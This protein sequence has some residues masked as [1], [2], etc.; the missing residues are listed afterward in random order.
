VSFLYNPGVL[1]AR[2]RT[3]RGWSQEGLCRGICA[4][5]YLSKIESG[6]AEASD[7]ILSL[8]FARLGIEWNGDLEAEAEALAEKAFEALFTADYEEL[9]KL[10]TSCEK[11]KY[12]FTT[13]GMELEL[14]QRIAD[15]VREPLTRDME[16]SMDTRALAIQRI[17]QGRAEEAVL[18]LPNACAYYEAGA[19]AYSRGDFVRAIEFLQ[20]AYKTA[21][22]DGSPKM[23]LLCKLLLA[24][25]CSNRRDREGIERHGLAA[26]R[27]AKALGDSEAMGQLDYNRAATAIECGNYEEAYAYFSNLK[28]PELMSLHKLAICCEKT[29]RVAEAFAALDKAEGMESAYPPAGIAREMCA[30]VR[31]RLENESYLQSEEYGERLL[32]LFDCC[33]RELSAGYAIFHLP[34][35]LEW[36]KANR[37]YK[38]ALELMEE[39]P[40]N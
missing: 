26:R 38:K 36:Y 18:L 14:L 31:F 37:Q 5:S 7:E 19:A 34:W 12:S 21:S 39:F 9:E 17:F 15:G 32:T 33:R 24:A 13:R 29:G 1:I 6:K 11:E 30:I 3:E 40:Q 28:H 25:C 4:V 2:A 16:K 35:V 23:M 10:L 27:L 22:N 8:L 20:T